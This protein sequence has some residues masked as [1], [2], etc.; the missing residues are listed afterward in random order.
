MLLCSNI[1]ILIHST[2]SLIS[3]F[4]NLE[5][6]YKGDIYVSGAEW[7]DPDDPCSHFKCVAGVVTESNFQCYTPCSN[8]S[9]PRP[10]QCCPTCL[11]E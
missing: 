1:I 4:S 9:P 5:C 2:L 10:G 8:P 11:G 7:S 6:L 3:V